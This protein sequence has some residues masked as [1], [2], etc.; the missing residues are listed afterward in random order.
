MVKK[1]PIDNLGQKIEKTNSINT[2]IRSS[3]SFRKDI[4]KHPDYFANNR[5]WVLLGKC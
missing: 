2:K 5:R 4:T 1:F 3:N